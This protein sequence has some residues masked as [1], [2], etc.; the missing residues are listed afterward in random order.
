ME[1]VV[2]LTIFAAVQRA[3]ERE[4]KEILWRFTLKPEMNLIIYFSNNR[5][6]VN[7]TNENIN[8]R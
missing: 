8:S 7:E 4:N 6:F 3:L 1:C 2:N 5:L